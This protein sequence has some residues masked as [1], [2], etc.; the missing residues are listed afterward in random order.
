MWDPKSC[1]SFQIH[2]SP[3]LVIT[4]GGASEGASNSSVYAFMPGRRLLKVNLF[5]LK[6]HKIME[7]ER[8][9]GGPLVQSCLRTALC[10]AS[11][12]S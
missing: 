9:L 8:A 10:S 7:L 5:Y 1:L 12:C 4:H 11:M 6:N 2:A 3:Y